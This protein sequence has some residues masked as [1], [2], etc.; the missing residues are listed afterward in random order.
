MKISIIIP[1]YNRANLV[2]HA[3]RSILR[4]E[5]DADLDIIVVD[6]GSTDDTARL[7]AEMAV[8]HP[9]IRVIRRENG[10]VVDAR[11]TGLASIPQDADLFTFLDSDDLMAPNRLTDDLAAFEA[12]PDLEM[13][14][15]RMILTEKFDYE[16]LAPAS[17]TNSIS[18]VGIHLSSALMKR[19]ILDRVSDFDKELEEAE[20]TDFLFRIFET[21]TNFL[22]TETVCHYYLRHAENMTHDVERSRQ[23][24]TKAV[25]KSIKRR[26]A[27]PSRRLHTPGFKIVQLN[28]AEIT[29]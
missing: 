29:K 11:N 14:Y 5:T 8:K 7:V 12:N 3:I 18:F 1:T 19:S 2:V 13:T 22:Q 20:D 21:K 24:F 15:G 25:F 6:D 16:K 27:D 26:R 23:Q 10:G 4:Q 28:Q 9:E 17:D